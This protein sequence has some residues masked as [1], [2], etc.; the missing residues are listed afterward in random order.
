GYTFVASISTILAVGGTPVLAEIDESLTMDPE[1][2][3]QRITD[4]VGLLLS[5]DFFAV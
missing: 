1:N 2:L 4:R 5:G 3:E